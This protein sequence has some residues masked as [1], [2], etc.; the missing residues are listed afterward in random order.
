[1]KAFLHGSKTI[2]DKNEDGFKWFIE[3][4]RV[5]VTGEVFLRSQ[6]VSLD[7]KDTFWRYIQGRQ[8]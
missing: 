4:P 3:G 7:Y 2:K 1:M 6:K 8:E 5:G